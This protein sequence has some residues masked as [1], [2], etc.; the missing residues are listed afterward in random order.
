[1]I[2]FIGIGL[3]PSLLNQPLISPKTAQHKPLS[4]TSILGWVNLWKTGEASDVSSTL[5]SYWLEYSLSEQIPK[6]M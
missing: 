5:D 3:E 1:M 6:R 4:Q 2:Y